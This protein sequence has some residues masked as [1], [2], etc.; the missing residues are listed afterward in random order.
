MQASASLL[1]QRLRKTWAIDLRS[2]P[3]NHVSL[4]LAFALVAPRFGCH[5]FEY[6]EYAGVAAPRVGKNPLAIRATPGPTDPPVV[7][8]GGI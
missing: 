5:F 8:K 4:E 2:Y 6:R 7:R 1:T 3:P